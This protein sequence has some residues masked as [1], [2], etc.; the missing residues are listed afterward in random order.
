MK[1][2]EIEKLVL[3][4]SLKITGSS[5]PLDGIRNW[6]DKVNVHLLISI[7]LHVVICQDEAKTCKAY[8]DLLHSFRAVIACSLR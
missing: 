3:L 8:L 4:L 1:L 7:I 5:D 2:Y 6:M